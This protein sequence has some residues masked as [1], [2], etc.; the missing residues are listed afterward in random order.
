MVLGC[1]E[2]DQS[3]NHVSGTAVATA[4]EPESIGQAWLDDD[5]TLKL[6]LRAEGDEG[7]V[8][9][10]LITYPPDHEK[11]ESTLRHL[12]GLKKGEVKPVPPW[13]E[14]EPKTQDAR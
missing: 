9:D 14:D 11:Y 2:R 8:G 1:A 7:A 6:Q 12:G 4:A 13:P 3:T 10:S 5:G